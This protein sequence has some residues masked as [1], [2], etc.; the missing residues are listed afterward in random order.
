MCISLHLHYIIYKK[1]N[2]YNDVADENISIVLPAF[3]KNK[4]FHKF[5]E[6]H[7]YLI[8]VKCYRM[9]IQM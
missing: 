4:C 7:D 8:I 9:F 3:Y 1:Y 2:F 5:T 6:Y